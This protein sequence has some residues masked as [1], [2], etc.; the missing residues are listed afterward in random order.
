M[1]YFRTPRPRDLDEVPADPLSRLRHSASHVL[2]DAVLRIRPGA[3]VAIG[4]AIEDSFYYNFDT[5]P[6]EHQDM[7]RIETAMAQIVAEDL[8]FERRTIS[9]AEALPGQA[10]E[11]SIS[12]GYLSVAASFVPRASHPL[13]RAGL[14]RYHLMRA[15]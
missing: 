3:K 1:L 4:P 2:A 14:H 8:P 10:H 5:E 6:F 13:R 7:E 9:R 12:C 11:L 15:T